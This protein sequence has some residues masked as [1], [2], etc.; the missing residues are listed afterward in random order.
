MRKRI[1]SAL[2]FVHEAVDRAM[3]HH[4]LRFDVTR[5]TIRVAFDTP[6]SLA[7]V[8]LV[9]G[10][11]F[12]ASELFGQEI[13]VTAGN[14]GCFEADFE[15]TDTEPKQLKHIEDFIVY[16]SEFDLIAA[17]YEVI[18]LILF[19]FPACADGQLEIRYSD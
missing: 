19:K 17:K 14:Y 12:D 10:F 15:P 16:E 6:P 3:R 9:D 18:H 11:I 2:P 1:M 8:S 7:C 5:P 4:R 13:R